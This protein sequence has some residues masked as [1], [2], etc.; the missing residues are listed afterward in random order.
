MTR[1][2]GR[3]LGVAAVLLLATLALAFRSLR[4]GLASVVPNLLPLGAAAFGLR[5]SGGVLDLSVL[6]ALTL[7]LG[8]ATADTIHVL[9]RWGEA[10]GAPE[11][12]ERAR[13][14]VAGAFPA[15]HVRAA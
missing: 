8:I 4:L 3:R 9:A 13:R 15:L 1:D 2:L 10:G 7:S 5:L 6:T 12:K 11:P 14:A